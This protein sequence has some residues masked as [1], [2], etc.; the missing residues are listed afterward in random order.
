MSKGLEKLAAIRK[1][2][3]EDKSVTLVGGAF[4]LLHPGHLHAINYAKSLGDVLVVS[5][6]S[7][8]H[9]KSYKGEQRPILPEEHRLSMV[10]ALKS[11]DHAF[12]PDSSSYS[13][14]N[15]EALRPNNLVFGKEQDEEKARKVEAQKSAIKAK[16]PNINLH[17]LDRYH[18][19]SVS[20]SA[21]IRK[22]KSQ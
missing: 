2:I 11:V 22:I 9:V 3:P 1:H 4:D 12:I 20:T 5:V 15:L 16:F 7:D 6:L 18:D 19:E 13:H 14:E 8:A 10:E 17:D 21:L